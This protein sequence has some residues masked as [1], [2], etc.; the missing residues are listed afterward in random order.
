MV[1]GILIILKLFVLASSSYYFFFIYF[2]NCIG[3]LNGLWQP[4]GKRK[5]EYFTLGDLWDCFSEWSA[6][7]VG[8]PV[9]LN[10]GETVSQYYVPYLSAIQI[11]SYKSLASPRY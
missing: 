2:Q 6:Y 9:V 1:L 10:N 8:T 7:G 5:I 11:Y 3:D 4:P